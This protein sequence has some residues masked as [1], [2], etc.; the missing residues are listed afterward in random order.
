[1]SMWGAGYVTDITYV[2]GVYPEQ[3]PELMQF[4][5]LVAGVAP[6]GHLGSALSYCELGF[7]LGVGLNGMAATHPAMRF[8]GT[9]FMPEQVAFA[10]EL[11]AGVCDNLELVDDSFEQFARR[12]TPEFDFITLHGIWSWIS[13]SNQQTVLDILAAKLK[14]GGVVYVSYN[15]LPGWHLMAPLRGLLAEHARLGSPAGEPA[16]QKA[17]RAMATVETMLQNRVP[18]LANNQAIADRLK[19]LKS[20][21]LTY[22]AHEFLNE[23]WQPLYFTQVAE[24]MQKAKL[25]YV[26]SSKVFRMIDNVNLPASAQQHL[27]QIPSPQLRE[28]LRDFYLNTVF[29][30]DLYVRGPRRLM[31]QERER[32]LND[33]RLVLTAP[34]DAIKL[35]LTTAAGE[36]ALDESIYPAVI[37]SLEKAGAGGMTIRELRQH[38]VLKAQPAAVSL[39]VGIMLVAIE[40]AFPIVFDAQDDCSGRAAVLNRRLSDFNARGFNLDFQVSPSARGAFNVDRI[41]GSFIDAYADGLRDAEAMARRSWQWL[42][43]L[44]Q[45]VLKEGKALQTPEENLEQLRSMAADFLKKGIPRYRRLALM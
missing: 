5:L 7:G 16:L 24:A 34:T 32:L 15:A 2:P 11:G 14:V 8:W 39:D 9:D 19:H 22:V 29:R 3:S 1:M 18:I 25:S 37:E 30:Q 38:P 28:V 23:H 21:P 45:K 36:V 6:P 12:S 10:R 40:A 26:G 20:M 44:G 27:Q 43:R 4:A 13:P 42:D 31:P 17:G 41:Q 35:K 33:V